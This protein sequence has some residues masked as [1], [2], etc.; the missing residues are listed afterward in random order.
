MRDFFTIKML[1]RAMFYVGVRSTLCPEIFHFNYLKRNNS[2]KKN[3]KN[4]ATMP[5]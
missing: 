3:F 4:A 2:L 5:D 1:V